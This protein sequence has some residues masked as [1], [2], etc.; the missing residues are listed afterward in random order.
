MAR[1]IGSGEA[2]VDILQQE[3]VT[4]LFGIVGSSFLDILD[5]L[6]DKETIEF[7]GTRH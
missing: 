4:H 5:S 3:Q 2:I 7:V 1:N 6:Y